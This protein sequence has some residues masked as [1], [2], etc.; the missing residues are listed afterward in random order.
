MLVR[1]WIV[2]VAAN[3]ISEQNQPCMIEGRMAWVSMDYRCHMWEH[4]TLRGTRTVDAVHG[5]WVWRHWLHGLHR[6]AWRHD[7]LEF[8]SPKR[9][10]IDRKKAFAVEQSINHIAFRGNSISQLLV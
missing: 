10:N 6:K 3:G 7:T 2:V 9:T 1:G 8:R 5:C 4:L